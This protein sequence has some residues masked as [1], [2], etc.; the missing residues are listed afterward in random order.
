M[1]LKRSTDFRRFV[2]AAAVWL[3]RWIVPGWALFV[4][5]FGVF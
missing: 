4:V 1:G 2:S 3:S 5:S